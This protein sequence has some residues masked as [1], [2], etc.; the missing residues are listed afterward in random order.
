MSGAIPPLPQYAFMVWCLVKAQ[1]R[2][3][4]WTEDALMGLH[5]STFSKTNTEFNSDLAPMRFLGFSNHEKGAPRQ[6][7]SKWSTVWSTFPRSG[8]SVVKVHR[9]PREVLRKRDRHRTSTKIRLG[10]IRWVHE[11]YER[12]SYNFTV[13]KNLRTELLSKDCV[14]RQVWPRIYTHTHGVW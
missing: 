13:G 7:I 4:D 14:Y 6:E 10:V 11:L 3:L 5:R 8:W 2:D 12:P 9:L 1:G